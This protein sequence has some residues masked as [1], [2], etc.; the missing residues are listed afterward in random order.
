V[1][2]KSAI[3]EL[4]IPQ[5]SHTTTW[6]CQGGRGGER[7]CSELVGDG[8]WRR[9]TGIDEGS[10][11]PLGRERRQAVQYS[12]AQSWL[13]QVN[14]PVPHLWS[15]Q[16]TTGAQKSEL[17]GSPDQRARVCLSVCY[18]RTTSWE[19]SNNRRASCDTVCDVV[20]VFI[21]RAPSCQTHSGER[22]WGRWRA[23]QSTHCWCARLG[24]GRSPESASDSPPGPT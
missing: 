14:P 20:M 12:N 6:A 16:Y 10:K 7:Y 4:A 23:R 18:P 9:E 15:A 11:Q 17:W 2:I 3:G 19:S 13:G 21:F 22:L 1:N 24:W 5:R 8:H